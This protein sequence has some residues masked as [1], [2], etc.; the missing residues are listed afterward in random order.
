MQ[1]YTRDTKLLLKFKEWLRSDL[2]DLDAIKSCRIPN[3]LKPF[4]VDEQNIM[5]DQIS[6]ANE[7]IEI[8]F[9]IP[10]GATFR[11]RMKIWYLKTSGSKQSMQN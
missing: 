10:K 7:D 4:K 11:E 2:T 9:M 1:Q 3:G 5:W 8:K 6:N